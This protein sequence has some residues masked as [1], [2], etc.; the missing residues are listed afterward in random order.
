[1]KPNRR[2]LILLLGALS[3]IGPFSID[4]Y[5]PGFPFISKAL[6]TSAGTVAYSLSSFFLGISLGQLIFGPLL[7]KFGRKKPLLAGLLV[8]IIASFG[9]MLAT[10]VETLIICRFFQALGACAGFVAPRAIVRDE[11]PLAE[12]ARIFSMLVLILGVSPM[13]APTAGSLIVTRFGWQAVFLTLMILGIILFIGTILILTDKPQPENVFSLRPSAITANFLSILK[14]RQFIKFTLI[15]AFSSSGF[16]CYLSGAPAVL[17]GQYG[18]SEKEF[19]YLFGLIAFGLIGSS[20]AN[21]YL[22]KYF[23]SPGIVQT[24]GIVQAISGLVMS[25]AVYFIHPVLP[26]LVSLLFILICCQGLTTPNATA[27]ALSPFTKNAGSASALLGTLQM[28][29]GAIASALVSSGISRNA[30]PMATGMLVCGT[31]AFT[32]SFLP[33]TASREKGM[34]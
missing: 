8:Y 33:G 17:M 18:I 23:S 1:M 11:F 16:Y 25:L 31:L 26:V 24:A 30:L 21:R 5:L 4:M 28:G 9:C 10:S 7:D 22:L 15:N 6:H 29:L 12:N 20:Q 14:T 19:G 34:L 13:L 27:M 3:A 2:I 32:F